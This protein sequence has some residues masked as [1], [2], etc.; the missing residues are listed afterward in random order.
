MNKRF[1]YTG[2]FVLLLMI[3]V[4][5]AIKFTNVEAKGGEAV[6]TKKSYVSYEIQPGDTLI[7]IAKENIKNTDLT[8]DEYVEEVKEN[9]QLHDDKIIA[10]NKIIITT[11][12]Y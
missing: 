8:I 6:A 12:A 9:N 2:S 11:Y 1:I 3:A 5:S 7:S 4:F 10:G